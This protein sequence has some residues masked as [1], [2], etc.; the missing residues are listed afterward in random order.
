MAP[1]FEFDARQN[2]AFA[3]LAGA[4]WFAGVCMI[5]IGGLATVPFVMTLRTLGPGRSAPSIIVHY[6]IPFF[7]FAMPGAWIGIMGVSL[8]TTTSR[9][10][11]LVTTAGHDIDNLMA[12]IAALGTAYRIQRWLWVVVGCSIVFGLVSA[13]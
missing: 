3:R 11:A 9:L 5:A 13:R 10:R 8:L 4:M 2:A 1:A 12:A 6:F 7:V